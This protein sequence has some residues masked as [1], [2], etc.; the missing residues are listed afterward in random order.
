MLMLFVIITI[1]TQRTS[2]YDKNLLFDCKN[3]E[4]RKKPTG[5]DKCW[6][7]GI[8]AWKQKKTAR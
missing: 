5:Y 6:S 2:A 7:G 4:N 1:L 8:G 3:W